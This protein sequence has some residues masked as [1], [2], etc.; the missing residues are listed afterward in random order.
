VL[1]YVANDR[2]VEAGD[3]V[4]LDAGAERS[5]YQGDITRT[6]PA[7]GAFTAEQRAVYEIVDAA[8]AAGV[9][10]VAPGVSVGDVHAAAVR[11]IVE[12]LVS[13]GVL[14]GEVDDL[15]EADAHRPWFPHTTSHWIGL[16]V[17]DPGDYVRDGASR[18]LEAG[19]VFTV[20]PGLYFPPD[21]VDAAAP[22]AGIGVRVEDDVAVTASGRENLT[23]AL[24]TAADDIEA[25]VR[26]AR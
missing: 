12:G 8:R 6:Y 4:L 9:G 17:H 15:V 1:H 19:M 11:V 10:A 5:L 24:P 13:L 16:D 18:A 26:S 22:F 25:L 23:A 2:V 3:L 20:E 21:A 7:D 14:D